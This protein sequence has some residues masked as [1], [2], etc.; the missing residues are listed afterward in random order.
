VLHHCD[1]VNRFDVEIHHIEVRGQ[2][3]SW[4]TEYTGGYKVEESNPWITN[5]SIV[6]LHTTH[7]L[8]EVRGAC[9]HKGACF[10]A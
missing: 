2:V 9:N 8:N 5:E 1:S 3:V 10:L 4:R 7:N 6:D